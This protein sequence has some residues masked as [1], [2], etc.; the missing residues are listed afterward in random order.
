MV[1]RGTCDQYAGI[2]YWQLFGERLFQQVVG[3]PMETNCATVQLTFSTFLIFILVG[4]P[5]DTCQEQ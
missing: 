1:H 3:I 2:S 4:V 5:S